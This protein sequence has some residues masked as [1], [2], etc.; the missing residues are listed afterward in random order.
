MI[1][2]SSQPATKDDSAS[3]AKIIEEEV[4]NCL[5]KKI[6]EIVNE[7]LLSSRKQIENTVIEV[8]DKYLPREI[9]DRVVQSYDLMYDYLASN[10]GTNP[11]ETFPIVTSLDPE[12]IDDAICAR[13][14]ITNT[15][16]SG[17]FPKVPVVDKKSN[18]SISCT[19][20]PST[21]AKNVT[22]VPA[23]MYYPVH[24]MVARCEDN[25][26][27]EILDEGEY[28][29]QM[30]KEIKQTPK[31]KQFKYSTDGDP[32]IIIGEFCGSKLKKLCVVI[33]NSCDCDEYINKCKNEIHPITC[34]HIEY[35]KSFGKN[36]SQQ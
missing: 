13:S 26:N 14:S 8:L 20:G 9:E 3:V 15:N 25:E 4:Q 5:R 22:A 28:K 19:E 16:R 33:D 36:I 35:A 29:E 23:G 6:R 10:D 2:N 31:F 34:P 32:S 21:A 30:L 17:V 7:R 24:K 12:C 11:L 27:G 18:A 1:T